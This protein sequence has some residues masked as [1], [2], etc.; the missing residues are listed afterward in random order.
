MR[1]RCS[2][3]S[4]FKRGRCVVPYRRPVGFWSP[5]LRLG[6]QVAPPLGSHGRLPSR[7]LALLSWPWR[8]GRRFGD[9]RG[10]PRCRFVAGAGARRGH[11]NCVRAHRECGGWR[12]RGVARRLQGPAS[13]TGVLSSARRVEGVVRSTGLAREA[14]GRKAG[15]VLAL[16][17]WRP[18]VRRSTAFLPR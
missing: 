17:G 4:F 14:L 15:E 10:R 6:G 13:M 12:G 9:G 18:G 5:G 3:G 2:R 11:F 7:R 1:N 16:A 8:R